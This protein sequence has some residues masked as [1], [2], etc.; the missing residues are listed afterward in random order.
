MALS[1]R[2]LSGPLTSAITGRLTWVGGALR[3]T[4]GLVR[5]RVTLPLSSRI[6]SE[7]SP[8]SFVVFG[9]GRRHTKVPPLAMVIF[10]QRV[11]CSPFL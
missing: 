8:M 5:V 10:D 4:I 11:I 2:R 3:K 7:T 9:S 6:S 1:T